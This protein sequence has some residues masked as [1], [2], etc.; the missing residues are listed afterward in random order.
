MTEPYDHPSEHH[1]DELAWVRA[2]V[3]GFLDFV[4]R[5]PSDD[6]DLTRGFA[7]S[8]REVVRLLGNHEHLPR[9][10]GE[11]G[12]IRD[13]IDA[14]LV[15]SAAAG[16]PTPLGLLFER[17]HLD[18][19]SRQVLTLALMAEIDSDIRRLYQ[20]CWNDLT[21]A[22]PT[23]E[24]LLGLLQPSGLGK[25]LNAT[26]FSRDSPLIDEHLLRL[27]TGETPYLA[28]AVRVS[29]SVV[30]WC[31]GGSE[32]DPVLDVAAKVT[33][34]ETDTGLAR[35]V[36]PP[37]VAA[38]VEASLDRTRA[39]SG[40]VTVIVGPS[41]T[42]KTTLARRRLGR[43]LEV[44]I[45]ALVRPVIDA[46]DKV[47]ALRRD[48]RMLA[49]PLVVDLGETEDDD[50]SLAGPH[51]LVARMVDTHPE[52]AVITATDE[53]SWFVGRL[54]QAV[55]HHVPLP[56]K[57]E[58]R[59][60]WSQAF[61]ASGFEAE[62]PEVIEGAIRYPL[63]GGS[64][65]RA[66]LAASAQAGVKGRVDHRVTVDDVG[67][68]CRAQLT[69]RLSGVAQRIVTTFSWDDLI[70]PPE[71][72]ANLQEIIAYSKNRAV[73]YD[74]WGYGRLLPYGRGLSALFAGPPGT[75]KTMAAGILAGELGMEVFRV[76][77]SR[78]VSKYI[79][80]TEKNLARVFDE[81]SKSQSILLFDEADSLF[82][83][84]TSVKSSVDRYA[85]LEVNYLLQ[86]MEDFEGVTILTTN[87]EGS[88]DDA[89]QRR[90]RFRVR[91]PAPDE[92]TR[93]RLWERMVP[94]K[95]K[96]EGE[97]YFDALGEDYEL[98]GGHIKNAALRAAFFAAN[99]GRG[100]TMKD[101]RR[102]A[103]LESLRLG[104]IVR[105]LDDVDERDDY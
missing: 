17:F 66:A 85:N 63:S 33:S 82:A 1:V 64:I 36:L 7:V 45:N 61:S 50:P 5:D 86:R 54:A 18:P 9:P 94:P 74:T 75:G 14:R 12:L 35:L 32:L 91:F 60:I 15:A 93:A 57:D 34:A 58:R 22:L 24:F 48:A 38:A 43:V 101:L 10:P 47:A 3:R 23:V 11:A 89:F 95:A 51:R 71:E 76:D 6:R 56:T 41:G 68:A 97:L 79:G 102:A 77:L 67:A 65:T 21:R 40:P 83:K 90:I 29:P 96:T 73:V 81:A 87:L 99:E 19:L 105:V 25:V 13:R 55:V 53:A 69:P 2:T 52:G 92:Q 31:I 78:T 98:S 103:R 37:T 100:I 72:V 8:A 30:S 104:K 46:E 88:I 39:P 70:L 59:Q 16:R 44:D 84:R 80:E 42:G 28:R 26:A 62:S 49:L 27:D 4:G 20:Y